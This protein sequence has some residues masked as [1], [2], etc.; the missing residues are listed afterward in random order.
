MK[1]LLIGLTFLLNISAQAQDLHKIE[2]DSWWVGMEMNTVE[3]MVYG[4]DISQLV[5]ESTTLEVLK[6]EGL[7]SPNYLFVT[8]KIPADAEVGDHTFVFRNTK[9]KK[10]GRLTVHI[11]SREEG[12]AARKGF[13]S[14]WLRSP[15]KLFQ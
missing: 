1:K 13:T 9:G 11:K 7:E 12:S 15:C 10:T 4:K 3:F 2:P 5:A 14:A 8:A 6:S